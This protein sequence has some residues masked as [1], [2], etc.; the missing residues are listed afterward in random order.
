MNIGKMKWLTLLVP[1]PVSTPLTGP[2][3][4]CPHL[5]VGD[6]QGVDP[7]P[8]TAPLVLDGVV[9]KDPEDVVNHLGDLLLLGVLGVDVSQ[10]EHPVLPHGALQQAAASGGEGG[11]GTLGCIRLG[12]LS[13]ST[14]L[15]RV[16]AS[17]SPSV[18]A[19]VAEEFDHVGEEESPDFHEL[20]A[21]R[22]VLQQGGDHF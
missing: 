16:A 4:C 5:G 2:C 21:G 3:V 11:G 14:T 8:P 1:S 9:E 15:P 20:G 19:A 17:C 6:G 7:D 18:F 22:G 12:L 13:L 10:R